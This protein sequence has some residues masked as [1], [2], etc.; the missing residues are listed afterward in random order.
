MDNRT[1]RALVMVALVIAGGAAIAIGAYN[2]GVARGVA[3]T[4]RMIAAPLAGAPYVYVWPRPWGFGFPF[5]PI[6]FFL[7]FFFVVRGMLWRGRWHGG[8]RYRYDGVPPMFDEWHRR[9][10]AERPDNGSRTPGPGGAS[11]T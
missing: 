9:A 10:H 3:E 11:T 6:L 8:W 1:L 4:G 7:F 5:F 2:A